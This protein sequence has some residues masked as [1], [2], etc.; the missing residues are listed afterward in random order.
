MGHALPKMDLEHQGSG[1]EL[2]T[3]RKEDRSNVNQCDTGD[4]NANPFF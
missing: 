2:G 3:I 1:S 4:C